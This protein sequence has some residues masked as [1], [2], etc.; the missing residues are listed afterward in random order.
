MPHVPHELSNPATERTPRRRPKRS[1]RAL[2]ATGI[3]AIAVIAV[4]LVSTAANAVLEQQEKS[5]TTKYGDLVKVTGGALNVVRAGTKGG[6]PLVLLSGLG[7]TAPAL[8]FAPLIRQLDAYDV[9]VV[10]GFGYGYSDMSARERT[11][12]NISTELHEV[13]ASL[14]IK[15]PVV[16]AG[17]SIAG[18]Y[19]L[20]YAN[21][22][23]NDVSAVVGIDP[24]VPSADAHDESD[25]AGGINFV[26]MLST[27]GV[28]R[29][30]V[31]LAPSVA[32]PSSDDFTADEL[33]RIRVMTSW[34]YGNAAVEDETARMASNAAALNGTTYPNNLPVLDFLS[35]DSMSTMPDWL[36][37]HENQLKNVDQHEIVKLDGPHYLHWTQSEAMA[38]KI[39]EF[40]HKTARP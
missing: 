24:T 34:N 10:E 3:V 21:R 9:I 27:T 4:T 12:K 29:T 5:S 22:Y 6:Q 31:A 25:P 1:L 13:L 20:D 16:L 38:E 15:K 32:D 8:D 2:K 35:S 17:H 23:P 19:T 40:L 26:R 28:V 33:D 7:T 18:F 30:V 39:T 36:E 14:D 37:N 11:V